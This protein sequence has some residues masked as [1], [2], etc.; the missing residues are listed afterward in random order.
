MDSRSC[1]G[2]VQFLGVVG[3][4]GPAEGGWAESFELRASSSDFS[5]GSE[6]ATPEMG[7]LVLTKARVVYSYLSA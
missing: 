7:G 5:L 6:N 4:V 3:A 1:A 2:G